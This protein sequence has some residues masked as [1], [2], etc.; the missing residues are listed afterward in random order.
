[1]ALPPWG[2]R[3]RLLHSALRKAT[4]MLRKPIYRMELTPGT[5]TFWAGWKKRKIAYTYAQDDSGIPGPAHFRLDGGNF[6]N[7]EGDARKPNEHARLLHAALRKAT[8]DLRTP[9]DRMEWK[10]GKIAFWADEKKIE[11]TY[12]YV[13]DDSTNPGPPH[14]LLDGEDLHDDAWAER[15]WK[16]RH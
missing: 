4:S 8:S 9:I 5:I 11:I 7:D 15:K 16:E 2:E 1:M 14:F 13:N 12:A 3:E 6:D 10:P